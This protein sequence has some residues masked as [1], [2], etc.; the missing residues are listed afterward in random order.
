MMRLTLDSVIL[1]GFLRAVLFKSCQK[2]IWESK[3]NMVSRKFLS[4]IRKLLQAKGLN[5]LELKLRKQSTE[6]SLSM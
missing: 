2:A 4:Q 1:F 5:R 6:K 3:R